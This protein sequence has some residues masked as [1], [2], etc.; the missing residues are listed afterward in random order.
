MPGPALRE[1]LVL[2]AADW[3]TLNPIN[4][5]GVLMFEE[6]TGNFKIADGSTAFTSLSYGPALGATATTNIATNVTNIATNVSDINVLEAERATMTAGSGFTGT[7]TIYKTSV[8]DHGDII[9]T[10]ILIDVTGMNSDTSGDII[11]NNDAANCHFGQITA[12]V[13]GTILGGR[14]TCLEAP[15]TAEPDID[16]FSATESTG[17]ENDAISGI[18]Q[19]SILEPGVNWTINLT[20]SFGTIAAN[21]YLY[22][23]GSDT[24]TVATYGG[25][26]FIIELY[27]YDA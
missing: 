26:K 12:A 4:E 3:T 27:G 9:K 11:G 21:Q 8:T 2:T 24:G 14:M 15:T 5:R 16:I 13:N 19:T 18:T 25:G 23:V 7:G 10:R 1:Y 6:D 17:T 22:L 20:K